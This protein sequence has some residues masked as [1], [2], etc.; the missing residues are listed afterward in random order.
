[1]GKTGESHAQP[2]LITPPNSQSSHSR[3]PNLHI[4]QALTIQ[5]SIF[6]RIDS[7]ISASVLI[8]TPKPPHSQ[9]STANTLKPSDLSHS[10]LK[11]LHISQAIHSKIA[12]FSIFWLSYV[13]ISFYTKVS[14]MLTA[15]PST[16]VALFKSPLISVVIYN[17]HKGQGYSPYSSMIILTFPTF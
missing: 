17:N 9:G 8:N 13:P 2:F 12:I 3:F 7:K 1:M 15:Q 11:N 5:T 14:T 4:C 6:V 10:F 16:I